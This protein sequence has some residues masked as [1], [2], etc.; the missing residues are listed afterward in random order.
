M[1]LSCRT[2]F[3][4]FLV[5]KGKKDTQDLLGGTIEQYL[6]AIPGERRGSLLYLSSLPP[7]PTPPAP[8]E[9]N[10][11]IFVQYFWKFLSNPCPEGCRPPTRSPGSTSDMNIFIPS[12]LN[13]DTAIRKVEHLA[14][15][16]DILFLTQ[17]LLF[18]LMSFYLVTE[19][20]M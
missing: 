10:V 14:F 15:G 5:Q 8:T 18:L 12:N 11:L 9:Q 1:A 2:Q 20:N 16:K 3:V 13:L 7:P 4:T 17:G 19:S 6:L